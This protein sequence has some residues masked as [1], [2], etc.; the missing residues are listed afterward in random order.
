LGEQRQLDRSAEPKRLTD[1]LLSQLE[2]LNLEGEA[3]VPDSYEPTLAELRA[4]LVDWRGIGSR[5]IERLQCGTSTTD[6]IETVF[7]IQEIISPPTRRRGLAAP[8]ERRIDR[9][10]TAKTLVTPGLPAESTSP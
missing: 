1:R 8:R 5:L 9:A 10:L 7:T 3:T 4:Q 2:E 6:L